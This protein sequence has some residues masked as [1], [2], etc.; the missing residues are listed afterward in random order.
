MTPVNFCF[1]K[2]KL[3]EKGWGEL[4]LINSSSHKAKKGRNS[5]LYLF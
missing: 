1:L 4:L 5:P 3:R 2:A